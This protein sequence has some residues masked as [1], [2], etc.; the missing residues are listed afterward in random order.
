MQVKQNKRAE[1]YVNKLKQLDP[2]LK[3]KRVVVKD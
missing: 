2:V 1:F 3:K